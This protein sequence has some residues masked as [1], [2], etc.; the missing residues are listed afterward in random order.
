MFIGHYAAAFAAKKV[1]TR[2]SLGT[3]FMAAQRLD[4][5]WPFLL[6]TGYESVTIEKGNTVFTPLNFIHYP[7]SHSL[8]AVV[9]WSLLFGVI[10]Y[11]L[12]RN[13][14]GA[15]VVG[16]LVFSHWALDWI[17]H[18]PDLPLSPF[19]NIKTGLGLW[20]FKYIAVIVEVLLF[21]IGLY[22]YT[23]ATK[24]KN[25]MGNWSLWLFVVFLLF[26]YTMNVFG[27]V[28]TSVNQ[29]A[30]AGLSQWLL[31]IWGYWIDTTRIAG[32]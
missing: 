6:L 4:L 13:R 28:P 25:K 19:G 23:T 15:I 10:Y 32:K 5:L 3:L 14:K 18:R 30:K 27:P 29:I 26:I 11:T 2:P 12:K 9:G 20:N 24:A 21:A 22:L 7:I 1:D 16:V 8:F 31:I 17:T